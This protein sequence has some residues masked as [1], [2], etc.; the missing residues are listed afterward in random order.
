MAS[1]W[2]MRHASKPANIAEEDSETPYLT[3]RIIDFIEDHKDGSLWLCHASFIKPHW[4]YIV[5]APYHNMYG[6]NQIQPVNRHTSE[7]T[8]PHPV[9]AQFQNNA[10]GQAF[11]RDEVRETVIPAYMGLIKQ[12]DDQLG[13]LLDYLETSGQL[14][15]TMIILTS[16]HGDYMG[17]HWLGEKD[18]FH[19]PSVKVPLIIYDPDADA[20]RGTTVEAL[21]EAIDLAPTFIE[22]MGGEVPQNILEGHSLLPFLRGETPTDW[23]EFAISEYD[24]SATPMCANLG[25]KPK[26]ARLFMVATDRYTFMHVEGGFSPML[27][28]RHVDPGELQDLGQSAAHSDVIAE[29]YGH[30]AEWGRR[31]SQRTTISDVEIEAKRGGPENVGIFIGAFDE[32]EFAPKFT[33]KLTGKSKPRPKSGT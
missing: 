13:R 19:E 20:T 14:D 18:L 16:D 30:L 5:P 10:V 15:D 32:S 1:G 2:F 17:D 27:F 31:M 25:L 24:Y 4:P 28:D 29:M 23:R 21:V 9:Y 8:D 22:A 26:D 3:S 12:C 11:A 7:K 6:H 33:E